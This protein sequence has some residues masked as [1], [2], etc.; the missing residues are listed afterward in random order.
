MMKTPPEI[1]HHLNLVRQNQTMGKV[2]R[3]PDVGYNVYKKNF[4]EPAKSEGFSEIIEINFIPQFDSS[5]DE[6]LFRQW[7]DST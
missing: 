7:T 4:E 5:S 1:A 6:R 2:R 3:I